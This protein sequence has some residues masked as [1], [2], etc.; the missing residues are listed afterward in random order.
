MQKRHVKRGAIALLVLCVLVF[1]VITAINHF[2]PADEIAVLDVELPV[3]ETEVSPSPLP[4]QPKPE[5]APPPEEPEPEELPAE[6]PPRPELTSLPARMIIPALSLDYEVQSMG[7]DVNG[8]MMIAPY[9]D[10][11]SWFDRS[12]I[13]GN[14]G[15]A[16]FGGHNLWRGA[17]SAIYT[18]DELEIGD[19]LVVEYEDETSLRFFLESVFVYPLRTAPAHLIMDTKG[20]SRLTLITCKPPFN[21]NIRTSDNRI[22]AIFKEEGVFVIPDPPI[23]M[24]PPR[25][26]PLY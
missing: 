14:E 4:P 16:I 18:L 15:N 24:Y 6:E 9:V 23:E 1:S 8:T 10:I 2:R 13:P 21:P 20:E 12:A 11:I 25:D 5:P 22:V 26:P 17:R 19:E 3:F 7:A